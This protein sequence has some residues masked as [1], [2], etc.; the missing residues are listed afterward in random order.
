MKKN[1]FLVVAVQLLLLSTL[2]AQSLKDAI[3]YDEN[4]NQTKLIDVNSSLVETSFSFKKEKFELS[5]ANIS[6]GIRILHPAYSAAFDNL[7]I[8]QNQPQAP[9]LNETEKEA[10]VSADANQA[11]DYSDKKFKWDSAI[12]QSLLFLGFQH[13][14]RLTQR[15]T[16]DE[17]KGP[18]LR[19][20]LNS[21]KGVRGWGDGDGFIT[22]YLGHPTMGAVSGYIQIQNDPKAMKL[23]I[24]R[25]KEY[26]NS[27]LKAMAWSAAYSTQFEIG[28]LSEATIGNVGKKSGTSG[29]VDF[30]V[31][32]TLGTAGVLFEDATD[33]FLI[34]KIENRTQ[35]PHIIRTVRMVFNPARSFANLLRFKKPWHR[36]SRGLTY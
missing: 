16:L 18:F 7:V 11:N 4:N 6:P 9:Q 14:L 24:G 2:H 19:D 25:S 3:T 5:K 32:P 35:N 15:K 13:G 26:W 30:V 23:V 21:I 1:I 31:T 33:S 34:R 29:Y 17:L 36:D 22:N 10:E 27:R 28:L 20:Y 12:R 8:Q